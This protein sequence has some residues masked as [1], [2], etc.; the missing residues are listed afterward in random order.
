M[1]RRRSMRDRSGMST[2]EGS[3]RR[4]VLRGEERDQRAAG[5]LLVAA[6]AAVMWV[7]EIIN[8]LS[9]DSLEQYG[10]VPRQVSGL[11]GVVFS[12]FLHANFGHLLSN[13]VPFLILGAVIALNGAMRVLWV[14]LIVGL[15]G[16]LGTWLTAP[17]HS[18]TVGASGLVFGYAAYLL[19]RG[20]FSRR[21]LELAV[22]IA[23]GVIWGG[24]L[25]W[26]LIPREGVSWQAHLFGAVG[27]VVAAW[28]LT[29][30]RHK[31]AATTSATP[32]F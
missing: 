2:Q 11:D 31:S 22:G 19:A 24:A 6:M 21:L 25:L 5:V 30:D 23:V 1:A 26:S 13:T 16:G 9:S 28:L 4:I 7:V 10:I 18:L 12:P 27:G 20:I 32:G 29:P 14:T 3:R 17:S 8:A 15:I